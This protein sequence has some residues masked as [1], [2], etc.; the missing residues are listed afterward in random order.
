M[1]GWLAGWLVF[2]MAVQNAPGMRLCSK[3]SKLLE[4]GFFF[5][6]IHGLHRIEGHSSLPSVD[7]ISPHCKAVCHL[8]SPHAARGPIRSVVPRREGNNKGD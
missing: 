4:P 1:G 2:E 7:K 3:K 8:Y 5:V 6:T